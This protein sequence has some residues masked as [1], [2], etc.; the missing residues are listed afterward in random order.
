MK[1]TEE[2]SHLSRLS[3]IP[4]SLNTPWI[5]MSSPKSSSRVIHYLLVFLTPRYSW[6][7]GKF[8]C[9]FSKLTVDQSKFLDVSHWWCV[10]PLSM[11]E[12]V[13]QSYH[14]VTLGVWKCEVKR[15]TM[16]EEFPVSWVMSFYI[17]R[18]TGIILEF[19][20]NIEVI[21]KNFFKECALKM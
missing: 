15:E 21:F 18:L 19:F 3:I 17:L 5:D 8:K 10:F 12:R 1:F 2:I 4:D 20:L 6:E 16:E 14:R 9:C 13:S 7:R 11:N